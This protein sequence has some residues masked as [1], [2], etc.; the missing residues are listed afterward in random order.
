[1]FRGHHDPKVTEG[2]ATQ[3]ALLPEMPLTMGPL[4]IGIRGSRSY[5]K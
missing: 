4:Y 1:M 2:V 5:G 3:W